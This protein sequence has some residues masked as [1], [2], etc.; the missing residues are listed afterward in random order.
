[1]A[2]LPGRRAE[3]LG[4]GGHFRFGGSPIRLSHFRGQTDDSGGETD[5]IGARRTLLVEF[6]RIGLRIE[7]AGCQFNNAGP[8]G[9][10]SIVADTAS[11]RH[12]GAMGMKPQATS[13]VPLP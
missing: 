7:G 5:V 4:G 12:P 10:V 13:G 11:R 9:H 8:D 1:M 6:G 2:L 3:D